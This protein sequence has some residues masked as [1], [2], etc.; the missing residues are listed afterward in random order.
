MLRFFFFFFLNFFHASQ[1]NRCFR[2]H[3]YNYTALREDNARILQFFGFDYFE[4]LLALLLQKNFFCK[5]C[6][7]SSWCSFQNFCIKSPFAT[8]RNVN[9]YH[10]NVIIEIFT[11][12]TINFCGTC[13]WIKS[14]LLHHIKI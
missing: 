2:Y 9:R 8:N 11:I 6:R 1:V 12:K 4:N 10:C 13:N 14:Y 7:L 5:K 3:K